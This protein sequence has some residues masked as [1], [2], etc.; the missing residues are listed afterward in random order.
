MAWRIARFTLDLVLIYSSFVLAYAFRYTI[1]SF[2]DEAQLAPVALSGYLGIAAAFMVVMFV[3][4]QF[5]QFYALPRITRLSKEISIITSSALIS[6]AAITLALLALSPTFAF[7][8]MIFVYLFPMTTFVL[9]VKSVAVRVIR[10]KRWLK[11]IGV[12]NLLVVGATDSGARL[13]RTAAQNA[14]L[15]YKVVGFVDDQIRYSHWTIP[16]R[17]RNSMR[18]SNQQVP[19]L[20]GLAQLGNLIAEHGVD[21]VSI[22]L[23]PED[24][25]TTRAIITRCKTLGIPFS[26]VPD[27][28]EM[29]PGAMVM[30]EINGMPIFSSTEPPLSTFQTVLKS[31]LDISGALAVLAV[32][33]LPMAIIAL[34]IRLDSP[35]PIIFKQTRVGKNGVPFNFYK[36]RSMYTDADARLAELQQFNQTD[37]ATFKMKNDPRVT[38]IGR[39]IRRY[40]L[41]ELP[42]VFNILF[43]QM[44]LV[45]PRPGLPREIA[46]YQPWQYRRLEVMPGLTGLWQVNG[47][48]ATTFEE[49]V[50]MDIYYAEHWS[51]WLDIAILLKTVRT[52]IKAEGAY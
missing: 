25:Q 50:R 27:M 3:S 1:L 17:Y 6:T 20:G 35:G 36:F 47:R 29:T 39:F 24:Y 51:L 23:P 32:A 33:W 46:R 38:R 2:G 30:H 52:V 48:S 5:K 8:R 9:A 16:A 34:L 14:E 22:A 10:R 43:R 45:G 11:G 13:M 7:S 12:R 19:H 15:G 37:G 26:V 31:A 42:Q 28:P 44:S 4:L 40:S 41:D 21:E 49:M 18:R